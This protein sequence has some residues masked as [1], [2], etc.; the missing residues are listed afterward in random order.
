MKNKLKIA[1]LLFFM[2]TTPILFAKKQTIFI[3]AE[4]LQNPG[5]WVIDQQSIDQIGSS[6][7]LAHGLGVP[8]E[9]AVSEIN[10]EKPGSY[11]VWVRSRNWAPAPTK[12][13]SPGRF[14]VLLNGQPLDTIF[15]QNKTT[16]NWHYGGEVKITKD[17]NEIRLHDL[18]GFEGRCDGIFFSTDKDLIQSGS[19]DA[20]LE[21]RKK[22]LGF[23]KTP[24]HLGDYELVVIGGGVAGMAASISSARLGLK[25][26]LIQ[27]RPVLGGNNSSEIR[28]HQSSDIN[29]EPYPNLGNVT[30]EIDEKNPKWGGGDILKYGIHTDEGK[31]ELIATEP[32]ITLLLEMHVIKAKV[33]KG[34]INRVLAK[35]IRTNEEY[36]IKGNLFVDCTGDGNLGYAAGADYRY[37][38]ESKTLTCEPLAPEKTDSLVLGSTLHWYSEECNESYKFPVCSWAHQFTEESCQHALKG[39]WNWE[40]GFQ[41]DMINQTEWIR[42]NMFRAIYGNWSFQKNQ[43]L[44][45]KK[46]KYHS[47]KWMAYVLGK[48]ESRRL[49]G[50]VIFSQHEIDSLTN[51]SDACVSSRWG[52][53][54]HTP[55]P[56]NSKFFPGE[57]FRSVAYHPKKNEH[58]LRSLPYRC[59]YSRNIQNLFMAGRCVSMT[60]VAHAMF[61]NQHTTG[62]MGEVVGIAASLCKKYNCQPRDLYKNHLDELL[63]AFEKGVPTK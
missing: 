51:F 31:L 32:N 13:Q 8:C 47:L 9:D 7:L 48:R 57:E 36:T 20:L 52:I 6:Y 19:E 42:D 21:L 2:N 53:D 11:H 27:N 25:V 61:R 15:G 41:Y 5:G 37:G 40:T 63:A 62:M 33:K 56:R 23:P 46:Y 28:V 26:A 1:L 38:R 55:D 49:M 50:D 58:P 3:E 22:T 39:A 60:H 18:T 43:S 10:F 4:S 59:F 35:N 24:T 54:I 30:R 12:E 44:H 14:Q 17:K 34:K 29:T 16:W 45:K